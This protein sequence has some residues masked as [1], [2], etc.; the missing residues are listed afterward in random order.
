MCRSRAWSY[1]PGRPTGQDGGCHGVHGAAG[2]VPTDRP[3]GACAGACLAG[4][5]EPPRP[6]D[7][8]PDVRC[9]GDGVAMTEVVAIAPD[10]RPAEQED[11]L[12][13]DGLGPAF[14]NDPHP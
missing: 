11:R 7:A 3:R 1:R 5:P 14:V 13:L 10:A 8:A 4:H 6:E 2:A 12:D 9:S